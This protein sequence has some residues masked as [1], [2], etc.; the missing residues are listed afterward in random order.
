MFATSPDY[1]RTSTSFGG[2]SSTGGPSQTTGVFD[3]VAVTGVA[4]GS[5]GGPVA[6][7][8][9]GTGP[10]HAAISAGALACF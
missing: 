5:G 3:R 4:S 7:I 1:P 9:D 10:G 2:S 8:A 6:R